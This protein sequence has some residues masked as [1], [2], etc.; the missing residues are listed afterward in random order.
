MGY[1]ELHLLQES[2]FLNYENSTYSVP[3]T[4]VNTQR[5]VATFNIE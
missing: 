1:L 4:L 5:L 2:I 3:A